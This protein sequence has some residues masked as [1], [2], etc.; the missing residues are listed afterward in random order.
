MREEI[1]IAIEEIITDWVDGK[2]SENE[3]ML[4]RALEALLSEAGA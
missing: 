3:A 4:R 1:E 2:R